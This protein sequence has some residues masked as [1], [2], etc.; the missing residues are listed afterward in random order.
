MPNL[1]IDYSF[2]CLISNQDVCSR[3]KKEE[4]VFVAIAQKISFPITR[5]YKCILKSFAVSHATKHQTWCPIVFSLRRIVSSS[6][7]LVYR[8]MAA[9]KEHGSQSAPVDSPTSPS[10]V[11]RLFSLYGTAIGRRATE[12]AII[13]TAVHETELSAWRGTRFFF[14]SKRHTLRYAHEHTYTH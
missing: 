7:E 8:I 10:S 14:L 9:R 12:S 13:N 11:F 2:L 1:E 3:R 6:C 5:C 4:I